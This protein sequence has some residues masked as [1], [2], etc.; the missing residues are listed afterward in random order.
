[1][2]MFEV[3]HD[4]RI[5]EQARAAYFSI[6]R[7]MLEPKIEWNKVFRVIE[8]DRMA[9]ESVKYSIFEI[10]DQDALLII[11]SALDEYYKETA[12]QHLKFHI[13]QLVMPY[14]KFARGYTKTQ[15]DHLTEWLMKRPAPWEG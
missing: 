1:M 6:K 9:L 13:H 5:V 7:L 11:Q 10:E 15:S 12:S 14:S 8:R 2:T 3:R 4:M